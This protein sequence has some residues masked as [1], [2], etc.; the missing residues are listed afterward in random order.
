[1]E[2]RPNKRHLLPIVGLIS[3]LLLALIGYRSLSQQRVQAL[4]AFGEAPSFIL[5]DHL[6][7]QVNSDELRGKVILA[8]FIYTSCRE[9]CPLLSVRMQAVQQ[10]LREEGLLGNGVQLLSFTVDPERDTPAVL[11]AY[12]ERHQADPN[13]WRFLTGPKDV[14]IP[15]LT[16]GFHL[17]TQSIPLP[18]ASSHRHDDGEE[19]DHSYDVMH[20]NRFVLIDRQWRVRAYYDG[21]DLT[22]EQVV[23]D[24]RQLLR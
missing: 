1:M 15:L 7:R 12:A 19:H 24:V 18:T 9:S 21:L 16:E 4:E 17:G 2:W 20:S 3:I 14:M 8:N 10:R 5:T 23:H 13:A 6:E 22:P 11:R